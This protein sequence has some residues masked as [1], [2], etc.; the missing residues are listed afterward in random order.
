MSDLEKIGL[1]FSKPTSKNYLI[2]RATF[3][4]TGLP[5]TPKEIDD[6]LADTSTKAYEKV[7][8]RLLASP[9]Y[10]ERM[11][12]D[13]LDI[14]R[15]A[16]SHG[17]Q[18]DGMRNVWPYRDWVIN[19]FNR[20][21]TYDQFV[22]QQLAGDLMPKPT[23]DM[24]VAT[25][26]NRNHP[27]TQEG[28]VVDEEY[29]VE[30]VADRTA[31]FGKAFLGMTV[32]CARC[33]DHKYDPIAQKDYYQ[34]FAYFN[35]NN[36]AGII[37]Y[38][39]E[40]APTVIIPTKE[41][42]TK[43]QFL[44]E[45]IMPLMLA[46][47]KENYRKDFENWLKL[48]PQYVAENKGLIA[49][50][51]FEAYFK[52][53]D[54]NVLKDKNI[55]ENHK[56]RDL[57][58]LVDNS[59]VQASASMD[60]DRKP[61]LVKGKYGNGM[62]FIG[63]AGFDFSDL[64]FEQN[65][66]FSISVWIQ[67]LKYNN[68]GTIFATSNGEFEGNRGYMLYLQ[69]DGRLQFSMN[70]V[71]PSNGIDKITL[72]KVPLNKWT[73]LVLTYDGKGKAEG[74]KLFVDG[75]M[76]NHKTLTDHLTK[77]IVYGEFKS[78]WNNMPFMIGKDFR[79]SIQDIVYDEIKVFDRTI[80]EIEVQEIAQNKKI[81][82]NYFLNVNRL[83]PQQKDMLFEWYLYNAKNQRFNA[84]KS[85]LAK[86]RGQYV[87]LLTDQPE[88]M[89]MT[90]KN[91]PNQ[92]FMLKRG[93]YDAPSTRVYPNTPISFGG[94]ENTYPKNRLGL[95]EW[96]VDKRNPL[97]SRV[98]VNRLWSMLFGKGIVLSSEDFGM[99]G[100][101]P[102]NLPLL[103]YLASDFMDNNWD[104]KRTIKKIMLS[105]TYQQGSIPSD[106]SFQKDPDNSKYSQYPSYRF[107][108]E[109]IRDNALAVS[110]LLVKNIGGPSVYP[111]QPDSLWEALAT[112]NKTHYTQGHGNDLYRRS[113]YTVWK[114]STPP[115][116][117]INFDAPDRYSCIIR[118]QKT[119]TPLQS[120]VLMNDPQYVEASR[121]IAERMILEGGLK[122]E[123]KIAYGFRILTSRNPNQNELNILVNLLKEQSKSY[124]LSPQK[125]Q[126]LL[127]VGESKAN[128]KLNKIELAAYSVV[129]STIMNFDESYIKR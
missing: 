127:E 62:K 73:N 56:M 94:F 90:D 85:D 119:S 17:Y 97:T 63:E 7:I 21:M 108:G 53:K 99:Q 65:Q 43:L 81:V 82:Q 100:A 8:D 46:A 114:R 13:W 109:M 37:P 78:H 103:N 87:E 42:E 118:R 61:V 4:I 14:A 79:G 28:G 66:S 47:D 126:K 54:K 18:D 129:A 91:T 71:K 115:P 122:K 45:K 116:S 128:P 77:S 96:L 104:I 26:F 84:N 50:F 89:I 16:D 48:K 92:T 39:G 80:S 25:C 101:L 76:A 44:K 120:L 93:A 125:A 11:A 67:L 3:D 75:K 124:E 24:L 57:K 10:G 121:K 111:Y 27:Q 107:S 123:N 34:L 20:N 72:E 88:V 35:N 117:M 106:A 9:H 95:A 68:E 29:R 31:T 69:K 51:D 102:S 15:Y 5:P 113:L 74:L 105:A 1:T 110:G 32:E 98:L 60:L 22:K 58:N 19:A 41:A 2:R 30:Y 59:K 70:Y 64:E 83:N 49:H 12:V 52:T 55:P 6:F 23:K 38:N 40:A 33:H 36:D 112:R 86:V